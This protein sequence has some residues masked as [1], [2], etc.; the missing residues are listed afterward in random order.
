MGSSAT[1]HPFIAILSHSK[2]KKAIPRVFRH[3]DDQQRVTILTM[4]VVLLDTL[5]VI[6]NALVTPVPSQIKEDIDLFVNAVM[7]ALFAHVNESP[8]PVVLGLL[9]LVLERSDVKSVVRTKVGL[10]ILTMIISRA[11]L[12]RESA[13]KQPQDAQSW[14]QYTNLYN[15]LF[16]TLEPGLPLIFPDDKPLSADDVHV[17]QFLAAMGV[18]AN[19]EQ[20]QRLVIGVK[21]RVMDTVGAARTLPTGEKERRLGEV[22]LFMRALGLDVELLA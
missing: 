14:Q 5:D 6:A 8:L 17:W 13:S 4:I 19:A 11:E 3:I 1:P 16:L 21:E 7:P 9:G 15:T 2:G 12:L 22:N 18:A 10:A 20:Q